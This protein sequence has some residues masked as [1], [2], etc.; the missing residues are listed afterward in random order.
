MQVCYYNWHFPSSGTNMKAYRFDE[1]TLCR[2]WCSYSSDY[3]DYPVLACDTDVPYILEE[4]AASIIRVQ[5]REVLTPGFFKTMGNFGVT[6]QITANFNS[7]KWK[8]IDSVLFQSISGYS[9]TWDQQLRWRESWLKGGQTQSGASGSPP[10]LC[11]TAM[12]QFSGS[13][14]KMAAN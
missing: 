7:N 9:L 14:T 5:G 3:K 1:R 10:T 2:T 13:F 6:T 4:H 12:T 11:P 8:D